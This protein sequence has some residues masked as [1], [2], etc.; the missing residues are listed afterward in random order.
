MSDIIGNEPAKRSLFE[1]VIL[2]I[3]APENLRGY[4]FCAYVARCQATHVS[5]YHKLQRAFEQAVET[6]C[7]SGL[8]ETERCIGPRP[9]VS[10][11]L[12]GCSDDAGHCCRSRGGCLLLFRESEQC[13][14]EIP[15]IA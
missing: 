15:G 6:C 7:Y 4:L 9:A 8:Q 13:V 10:L 11:H 5:Q 14:V 12:K 2:P 1:H 3:V